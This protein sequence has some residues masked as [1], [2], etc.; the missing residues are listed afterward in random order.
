MRSGLQD[1]LVVSFLVLGG[2]RTSGPADAGFAAPIRKGVVTAPGSPAVVAKTYFHTLDHCL[3][4]LTL[5]QDGSYFGEVGDGVSDGSFS[6]GQWRL[7]E[8]CITLEV[9][10]EK[11]LTA[12]W[13]RE[14][15]DL[16]VLWSERGWCLLPRGAHYRKAY[17]E[18]GVVGHACFVERKQKR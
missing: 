3:L 15:A 7:R 9:P 10:D 6:R 2:C 16:D 11:G 4:L 14:C 17:E 5:R 13:L 8:S 18:Y 1:L 12:M